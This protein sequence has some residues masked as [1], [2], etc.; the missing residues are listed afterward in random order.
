MFGA[1]PYLAERSMEL[2]VRA[3]R[4]E[5]QRLGALPLSP[6][7]RR[8]ACR[9]SLL[10]VQVGGRLVRAGLPPYQAGTKGNA[11]QS[12]SHGGAPA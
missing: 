1:D 12:A 5:A 6:S 2:N 10:M 8:L 3:A 7:A 11:G 4:D 9:L